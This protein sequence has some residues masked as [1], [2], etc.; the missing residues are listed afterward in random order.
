LRLVRARLETPARDVDAAEIVALRDAV[1]A[2]DA[3]GDPIGRMA[4]RDL[5]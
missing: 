5:A 3:D 4:S 2:D 1:Q